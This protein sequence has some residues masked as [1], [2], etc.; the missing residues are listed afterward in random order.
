M[1]G[2]Q[3]VVWAPLSSYASATASLYLTLLTQMFWIPD[4]V[5]EIS[6]THFPFIWKSI[7]FLLVVLKAT[8]EKPLLSTG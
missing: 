6:L 5:T 8:S 1:G 3:A 2:I 7:F 4:G